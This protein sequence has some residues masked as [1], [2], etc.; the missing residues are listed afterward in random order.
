[1]KLLQL[2]EWCI[3]RCSGINA[4]TKR[5]N[6]PYLE[7]WWR[8]RQEF[9]SRGKMS[10]SSIDFNDAQTYTYNLESIHYKWMLCSLVWRYYFG[11]SAFTRKDTSPFST[12]K[13]PVHRWRAKTTFTLAWQQVFL[14]RPNK[15]GRPDRFALVRSLRL[16]NV[17]P[18]L[19][20]VCSQATFT[21]LNSSKRLPPSVCTLLLIL[22]FSSPLFFHWHILAPL[23]SR[24]RLERGPKWDPAL[25]TAI[26]WV[27]C[28][29]HVNEHLDKRYSE[30]LK[31]KYF[32]LY[33]YIFF[34][35]Q[36]FFFQVCFLEIS[37]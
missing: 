10:I 27:S 7:K 24:A 16:L 4:M 20:G 19:V 36:C 9:L 28:C 29:F 18:V 3:A 34:S 22:A 30:T 14:A 25:T 11:Q 23:Y 2:Y 37:F 21:L 26:P 13:R 17:F 32:F 15:E 33:F 8:R 6:R 5:W 31:V 12:Y 35:G 1:M